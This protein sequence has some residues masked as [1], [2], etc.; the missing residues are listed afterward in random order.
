M[1]VVPP[2]GLNRWEGIEGQPARADDVTCCLHLV[3][4]LYP[5]MPFGMLGSMS[6]FRK[7]HIHLFTLLL[8]IGG[9]LQGAL[10]AS[11]VLERARAISSSI[12]SLPGGE[13]AIE[14]V[15]RGSPAPSEKDGE[16]SAYLDLEDMLFFKKEKRDV[17]RGEASH[18]R[19]DPQLCILCQQVLIQRSTTRHWWLW[20][21]WKAF[22]QSSES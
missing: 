12:K 8:L 21:A 18:P 20:Q 17:V 15:D 19:E 7:V 16:A 11:G 6:T 5:D 1:T 10:A 14:D 4:M 22:S 13:D 3:Q 9:H 2:A